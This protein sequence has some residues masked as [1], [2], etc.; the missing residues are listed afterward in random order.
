M[1]TKLWLQLVLNSSTEINGKS[2]M[3]KAKCQQQLNELKAS[4]G[5]GAARDERSGG[6]GT[7]EPRQDVG[8]YQLDER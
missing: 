7:K 1:W 2:V 8:C 6:R 5:A 3:I 4:I